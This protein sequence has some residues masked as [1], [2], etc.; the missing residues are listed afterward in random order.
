M[1]MRFEKLDNSKQIKDYLTKVL[2]RTGGKNSK[3]SF[4][5][6][7]SSIKAV[8]N[9]IDSGYLWLSSTDDMNDIFEM[10]HVQKMIDM[11]LYFISF[12]KNEEN[13]GMY[14]MYSPDKDG[15]I[16]YISYEDARKITEKEKQDLYIVRDNKITD[17]LVRADVFWSEVAYKNL[18]DDT[19][20]VG[21]VYNKR[22]KYPLK[23]IELTGYIKLHGW[24][25]EKE[26]RLFAKID[27]MIKK[28]EKV[29]LKLPHGIKYNIITS[30]HFDEN[31][32]INEKDILASNNVV[33]TNSSYKGFVNI[34][35]KKQI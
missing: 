5:F 2:S 9:I 29:A 25:Y 19:I 12:S 15:A 24:E 32:Y 18:K 17:E 4:L 3:N 20:R 33:I 26:V 30:P 1:I 8:C 31:L 16:L 11:P 21:G 13:M 35:N 6:H 34:N 27:K 14:K 10:N 22:I 7:Y 23:D 28:N